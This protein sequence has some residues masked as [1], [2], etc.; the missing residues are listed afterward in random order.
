MSVDDPEAD[1]ETDPLPE[2]ESTPETETIPKTVAD[3]TSD[4]APDASSPVIRVRNLSVSFGELSVLSGVDVSVDAGSFVGLVGPNGAGKTTLL[5][6]VKGTLTPDEGSAL[7]AGDPVSELSAKATGRRVASVPQETSLSFDFPVRN[8]V[9]MGRT[10][11]IDRFG[12]HDAAD[13]EAVRRAM[14]DAEVARFADRPITE[15]SGG[16]RGRVLLARALA[17]ETPAL[18]LDEPTAS[19]DVN[20]AVR[21]LELVR[22]LVDGGKAAIAAIHDLDMAARYCDEIVLLADGEVHATGEPESV[23][24]AATLR[25]AFDA[26]AFVGPNPVTATPTVTS[27]PR[28]DDGPHRVHVVG[29]GPDAARGIGRLAAAGHDLSVGV[30]PEGD[31]AERVANAAGARLATVPPFEDAGPDSDAVVR[32]RDL[33]AAADVTL[34]V[35]AIAGANRPVADAAADVARIDAEDVRD[36]DVSTAVLD[37]V[38]TADGTDR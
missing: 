1:P 26:E 28:S 16:E 35:G 36:G 19:L 13:A 14:S 37:A 31:V 10:P 33:S 7:L 12:S 38:D 22:E 18:L 25:D 27:F 23:L 6:V 11:H 30:V 3:A 2:A 32:A 15:I 8:V 29:T 20:H 5:R 4:T 17:Q 24:S 9:E 21:T 34:V